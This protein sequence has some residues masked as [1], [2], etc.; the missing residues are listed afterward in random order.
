MSDGCVFCRIAAKQ[1]PADIEYEDEA[2]LVLS[3]IGVAHFRQ[4][5]T[6]HAA[7]DELAR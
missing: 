6:Q 4:F 1:T 7:E 2:V 3:G 5:V